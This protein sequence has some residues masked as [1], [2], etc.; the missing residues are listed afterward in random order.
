M[1]LS[2]INQMQ[3]IKTHTLIVRGVSKAQ[4]DSLKRQA[5]SK[6]QSMNGFILSTVKDITI[7]DIEANKKERK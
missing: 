2:K 6:N 5:R 4:K 1:V 7:M 3:K